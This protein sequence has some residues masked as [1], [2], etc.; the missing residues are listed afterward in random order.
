MLNPDREPMFFAFSES[1][2]NLCYMLLQ[3][4]KEAETQPASWLMKHEFNAHRASHPY[5]NVGFVFLDF[6]NMCRQVQSP[7]NIRRPNKSFESREQNHRD[8]L[9]PSPKRDHLHLRNIFAAHRR[10]IRRHRILMH[11]SG[12]EASSLSRTRRKSWMSSERCVYCQ[13][14]V[15]FQYGLI[16]ISL[17][18]FI[19]GWCHP[20]RPTNVCRRN[21][22]NSRPQ[23]E[24]QEPIRDSTAQGP[25]PVSGAEGQGLA[26][27]RAQAPGD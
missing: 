2:K 22:R 18:H 20:E 16:Y 14:V 9:R 10:R 23:L 1:S 4:L 13:Q 5:N 26:S 24:L 11:Q 27:T 7:I 12:P 6:G 3:T 17:N 21:W 25:S 19:K 15:L 8:Q